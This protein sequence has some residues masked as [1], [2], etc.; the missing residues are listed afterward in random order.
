VIVRLLPGSIRGRLTIMGLA[1]VAVAALAIGLVMA[2]L[3]RDGSGERGG[4]GVALV[5]GG[6][7]A[8]AVALALARA[9]GSTIARPVERLAARAASGTVSGIGWSPGDAPD[10]VAHLAAALREFAGRA[11]ERYAAA[12]AERDRSATLL[13]GM[14]DAVFSVTADDRLDLVNPAAER[15]LGMSGAGRPLAE[16][17]RD[18]ELLATVD[19]ARRDGSASSQIERIDPRR[20]VRVA[21]WR[22]PSNDVLV[23]AQDLTTIRRLETVRRDFIANVSHELR[24]P[25][26]SIKAMV[27]T[28]ESGALRDEHAARDFVA[29]I[30][31]EV[32]DLAQLVT[33]LL[34][35]ARIE[36]GA[37]E[38]ELRTLDPAELLRRAA[39]RMRALGERGG[40]E[41]GVSIDGGLPP[42]R[43]DR[44]RIAT[45][46]ANLIHNA[47]KFTP[48]GGR[49]E[50]G[51]EREDGYVAF[52]VRDTGVGIGREDLERIFERFYK[53]DAA[54]SQEGTGLGLAIAR[55]IVLAHGG[56]IGAESEGSGRG[57]LF[58]FTVPVAALP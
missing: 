19:D 43:A 1:A 17:A 36:S 31:R 13:R 24:T 41:L 49:V 42:V 26:A 8:G 12:E 28:L 45:V 38:L 44:D 52:T 18:H 25:I 55:H 37:E 2:L 23:T 10:E 48:E 34:S 7:I 20:S 35:L 51:A 40:V 11:G 33:E 14:G 53:T 30:H 56:T 50:L 21:A 16:V 3:S 22:L 57:S 46:L 54:R 32:D 9:T 58:R 27:E 5:L 39:D 6:L 4:E 29:R 47:I 15:L